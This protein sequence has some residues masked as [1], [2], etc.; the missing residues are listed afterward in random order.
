MSIESF[1]TGERLETFVFN[2]NTLEHLHRYALASEFCKSKTVLDIASGEGYGSNILSNFADHVTGVDIDEKTI[3]LATN[4]YRKRNLEFKV[5][6]ADKIP[7]LSNTIDV[8]VSFETLEHHDKHDEMMNE[9]K[10]VLKRNGILI[11]STPDKKYYSDEPQYKNPFHVKELYYNQF[12]ELIDRNFINS[13]FFFQKIVNAS[14][15]LQENHVDDISFYEGDFQNFTHKKTI[16]P[17]YLIAIA[18]DSVINNP[19]HTLY[20]SSTVE[21]FEAEKQKILIENLKI[22][23]KGNEEVIQI[24]EEVIRLVKRSWSYKIGNLLL[25]PI[26]FLRKIFN[27]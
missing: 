12:R 15:I 26:R 9:I 20:R 25:T 8:V 4:K 21:K 11:I 1:W 27:L 10:R 7:V 16:N 2:E 6:R 24:K 5:G 17:V 19:G 13:I 22:Q 23:I 3:E 18:S 14:L